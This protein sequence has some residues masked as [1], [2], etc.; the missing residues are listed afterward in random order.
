MRLGCV[1][2]TGTHAELLKMREGGQSHSAWALEGPRMKWLYG[3]ARGF[4]F[5]PVMSIRII[6]PP[7]CI[8]PLIRLRGHFGP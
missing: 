3:T 7:A 8:S 6:I 1:A 2:E 5:S 4:D